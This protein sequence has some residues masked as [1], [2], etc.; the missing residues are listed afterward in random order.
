MKKLLTIVGIV[1]LLLLISV[2]IYNYRV[3][4][5]PL[6]I[7]VT[8]GLLYLFM[9]GILFSILLI[10]GDICHIEKEVL[11]GENFVKLLH[12]RNYLQKSE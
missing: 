12:N 11:N 3:F 9:M 8:T 5:V 7:Q 4:K 10:S 1:I 6:W 2:T